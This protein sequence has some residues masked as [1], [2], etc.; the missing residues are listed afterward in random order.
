MNL[1][2]VEDNET[3]ALR[4]AKA[5]VAALR[6]TPSISLGS[7]H[8]YWEQTLHWEDLRLSRV[9][10]GAEPQLS[11]DKAVGR[12]TRDVAPTA[13]V[14]DLLDKDGVF[15]AQDFLSALRT[16]EVEQH[17]P[18]SFVIIWSVNSGREEVKNFVDLEPL[19]DWRVKWLGTKGDV[20]LTRAV[21]GYLRTQLELK[22]Q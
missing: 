17:I 16:W 20:E 12:L 5:V 8:L 10:Q 6:S 22:Y 18:A 19:R 11:N 4:A 3:D 21:Q 9:L 13:V 14:L 15:K 2:I 1:W 7:T